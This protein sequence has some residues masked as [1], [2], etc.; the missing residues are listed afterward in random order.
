MCT[1]I[2][3][4]GARE[5]PQYGYTVVFHDHDSYSST[6]KSGFWMSPGSIYKVDL[7]LTKVRRLMCQ[8]VTN[9]SIPYHP[10]AFLP[11]LVAANHDEY[12]T[13]I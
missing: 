11:E 2:F 1:T 5:A 9:I 13:M 4:A 8:A 3:S 6:I 10:C 7:S 12:H